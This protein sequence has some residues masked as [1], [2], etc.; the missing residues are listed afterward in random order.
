MSARRTAEPS[1]AE[2]LVLN[3]LWRRGGASTRELLGDLRGETRWAYTTLKTVLSRMET[4]GLVRGEVRGRETWYEAAIAQDSARK[5]AL[6]S[7]IDKVF[8]GAAGPLLA[9]LVDDEK[10][11][12]ADRKTLERWSAELDAR[13]AKRGRR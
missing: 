7:L 2:W 11:S 1:G 6:R 8:D 10:L 5:S 9:H 4:K 13:E 12:A 3:C